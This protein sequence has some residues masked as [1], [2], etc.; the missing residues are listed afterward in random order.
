MICQHRKTKK[1]TKVVKLPKDRIKYI[2]EYCRG[3][4]AQTRVQTEAL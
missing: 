1:I 4:R 3:C 2:L